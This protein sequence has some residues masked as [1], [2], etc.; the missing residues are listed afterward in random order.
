MTIDPMDAR[1]SALLSLIHAYGATVHVADLPG[2]TRGRYEDETDRIYI[3]RGMSTAQRVATL[4]HEAAHLRLGHRGPQDRCV[5]D[6]VNEEAAGL[7]ITERAYALAE[8]LVGSNPRLLAAQLDVTPGLV[9]ACQ[10]RRN[11]EYHLPR[12]V[13][14]ARLPL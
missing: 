1:E 5:E 12:T 7:I 3:Q 9:E 6:H 13:D 4:A 2:N 10:R 14:G 8:T 11:R